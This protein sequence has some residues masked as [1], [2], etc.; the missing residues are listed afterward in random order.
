MLVFCAEA[1]HVDGVASHKVLDL[2]ADGRRMS[3]EI[4]RRI[5]GQEA[6]D[7][8][9]VDFARRIVGRNGNDV[10]AV[11]LTGHLVPHGETAYRP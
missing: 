11:A 10:G 5:G 2:R 7:G 4:S 9:A 1:V 3:E 6:A 8:N